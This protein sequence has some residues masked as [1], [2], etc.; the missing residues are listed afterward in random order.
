M[1]VSLLGSTFSWSANSAAISHEID[2]QL[3]FSMHASAEPLEM[4]E[5]LSPDGEN[6]LDDVTHLYLHLA[7]HMQLFSS[8]DKLFIQPGVATQPLLAFE[9]VFV[10]ESLPESLLRPPKAILSI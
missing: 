1:L 10:P 8:S 6:T 4:H 7:G 9:V 2:H 5:H 3:E